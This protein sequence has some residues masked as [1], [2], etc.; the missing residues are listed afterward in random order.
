MMIPIVLLWQSQRAP[1]TARAENLGGEEVLISVIKFIQ[2]TYNGPSYKKF[3]DGTDQ[4][5]RKKKER[6]RGHAYTI[7][8]VRQNSKFI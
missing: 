2:S 3:G 4:K 1:A 6:P 5:S 7:L 8:M